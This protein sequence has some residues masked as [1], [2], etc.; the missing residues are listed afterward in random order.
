MNARACQ[1]LKR[2]LKGETPALGFWVTLESPTITEIAGRMGLDWVVIDAEHGHLDFKDLM[3]HVRVANLLG[4]VCLVRIAEIHQGLIK[5]VLDI[6]ADGILVPQVR[7]AEE[8]AEAVRFAKYPP[9]GIRG[10]GAERATHWGKGLPGCVTSANRNIMVIPLM[11]RIEAA[12][13]IES[14]VA[15]PGID[16]IFFGPADFSASAGFP[17][18]WEGPGVAKHLLKIQKQIHAQRIPCGIICRGKEDLNLRK[19]QNFKML[20][21]GIDTGLLIRALGESMT[22]AGVSV[23]KKAW[24]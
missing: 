12:D 22:W 7:N 18:S 8:L 1:A 6:G 5:R 13:A 17:G 24:K 3:E 14:I 20:G 19:R 4:L 2:K 9:Q 15:V 23:M 16:A 10:I 21:L 11:E